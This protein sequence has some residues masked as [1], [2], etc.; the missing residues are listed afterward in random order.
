MKQRITTAVIAIAIMIPFLI[1]SRSP[2]FL[3]L[4]T[5]LSV[6]AAYE[7]LGCVGLR[8]NILVCIPTYIL[9]VSAIITT[10]YPAMDAANFFMKLFFQLFI[11]IMFLFSVVVFSKNKI[12]FGDAAVLTIIDR[13]SVV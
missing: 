11:Y 5:F 8:G 3:V 12:N 2:A 4:V 10:R 13:K 7:L 1:F 9:S 6:C